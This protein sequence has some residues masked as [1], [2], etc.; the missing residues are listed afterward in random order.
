M[1]NV[2]EGVLS[3]LRLLVS[4]DP[5]ILRIIGLSLAVSVSAT[6]LASLA[7]IPAGLFA[8]LKRFPGKRL[9]R[10]VVFAL[11]G[12]P[13]VIV[14]LVV[15]LVLSRKGP[16][17]QLQLLFTPQAMIIAQFLLVLPVVTGIVFGTAAR[18]A[19]GIDEL[20]L[21]LGGTRTQR[22]FLLVRELRGTMG[23]AVATA[24]GRAI[25]EVG[26]VMLVGGN[27]RD[28]TRVMTTFIA[29]NNNMGEYEKS[30]AMGLVLL[31]LS[32]LLHGVIQHFSGGAHE[33]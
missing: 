30:I 12:I 6:G 31:L 26:A 23:L 19:A 9:F 20:G 32:L 33:R 8:G 11:M 18:D 16:L 15:M 2:R 25:S 28:K 17:G 14:G 7:G 29:M 21:T 5:E 1:G 27:I 24:F 10:T 22:L 4:G 3:A 13:P